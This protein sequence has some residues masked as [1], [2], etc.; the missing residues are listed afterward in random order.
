MGRRSSRGIRA[1]VGATC[2]PAGLSCLP[3]LWYQPGVPPRQAAGTEEFGL[4]LTQMGR[5]QESHQDQAW[6]FSGADFCMLWVTEPL[7]LLRDSPSST[8]P[9]PDNSQLCVS[10]LLE[11]TRPQEVWESLQQHFGT[12]QHMVNAQEVKLVTLLL[13]EA[14]GVQSSQS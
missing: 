7:S 14:L 5:A 2:T 12:P 9:S 10:I 8:L 11:V 3:T 1:L 4:R 6:K 13:K